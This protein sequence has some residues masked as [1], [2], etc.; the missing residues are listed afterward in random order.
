MCITAELTEFLHTYVV[1]LV[2]N[3]TMRPGKNPVA[4]RTLPA[5]TGRKSNGGLPYV[6]R[7][8]YGTRAYESVSSAVRWSFVAVSWLAG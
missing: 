7:I 3:S 8:S 6:G 4:G 1:R 2:T 5:V